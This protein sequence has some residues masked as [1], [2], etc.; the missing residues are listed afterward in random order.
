MPEKTSNAQPSAQ[1]SNAQPNTQ[2]NPQKN[3]PH[4]LLM[5]MTGASGVG[6]GTLRERWLADQDV[7]Y[8]TSWTTRAPRPNEVDGRDYIFV[9]PEK[10]QEHLEHQ[11]FLEHAE[12]VGNRYGTPIAPIE[13]A[14]AEGT[15]VI[16]EIEV[17]GA[18][19]VKER[20]Q[21]DVV[22]IF[23]MPPSLTEL[24]RRLTERG[25]ESIE[26]IES[27]L[28]RAHEEIMMAHA[29]HYVVMNDDLERAV[30]E[31]H[32]IQAVERAKHMT[33]EGDANKSDMVE[34]AKLKERAERTQSNHLS[35]EDLR[36]IA[37]S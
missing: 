31:L 1:P 4:G 6:K 19:Q 13:Q 36:R 9:S 18:M 35:L 25:T 27:R 29:F 20:M 23:I 24:R 16:L 15:D 30:A 8:S 33:N 11:G 37:I 32:A 22:L 26:K 34:L 5:V 2:P 14:T 28:Q 10:F 12:F 17:A 3:V 7:F 21:D